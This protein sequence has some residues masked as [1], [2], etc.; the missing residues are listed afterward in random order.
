M[1]VLGF[2]MKKVQCDLAYKMVVPSAIFNPTCSV[3]SAP[4]VDPRLERGAGGKATPLASAWCLR[5]RTSQ[6]LTPPAALPVASM[7]PQ[8]A[9][10]VIWLLWATKQSWMASNIIT[11]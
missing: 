8:P 7:V 6:I 9:N 5:E 2:S 10:E 1:L 4:R 3:F 11:S